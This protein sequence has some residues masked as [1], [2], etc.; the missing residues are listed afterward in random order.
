MTSVRELTT[1]SQFV[2]IQ[3]PMTDLRP[4]LSTPTGR[5]SRPSWPDPI[6]GLEFVRDVGMVRDL[7]PYRLPGRPAGI[8]GWRGERTFCDASKLVRLGLSEIG[9]ERTW[10][11]IHR[12]LFSADV[13]WRLDFG[14]IVNWRSPVHPRTGKAAAQEILDHQV[15][16]QQVQYPMHNVGNA[17]AR[18]LLEVTTAASFATL[19]KPESWWM[20]SG[21]PCVLIDEYQQD[22]DGIAA[23]VDTLHIA[24]KNVPI[25]H[26]R[27]GRHHPQ[28]QSR[29]F[30][31]AIWRA[32]QELETLR[33]V[34]RA[35]RTRPERFSIQH[36]RD[37]L[38]PQ[39]KLLSQRTRGSLDQPSILSLFKELD[40]LDDSDLLP[41][42]H[43]VHGQSKGIARNLES[44][45]RSLEVSKAPTANQQ[46]SFNY[47]I[48]RGGVRMSGDSFNFNDKAFGVFGSNNEVRE[49]NFVNQDAKISD[50]TRE[51]IDALQ[52]LNPPRRRHTRPRKR[53]E[54]ERSVTVLKSEA[55]G[56]IQRAGGDPNRIRDALS[57]IS[58]AAVS[59]G[60]TGVPVIEAVNKLLGAL[61]IQ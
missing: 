4:L 3:F 50:A 61:G 45:M 43:E 47:L 2:N 31:I 5:L 41:L 23:N 60:E 1:S 46:V 6:S 7:N 9:G 14:A 58:S 37:Y 48:A 29:R 38:A 24:G 32:Y 26:L 13:T 19:S 57:K 18:R 39:L 34:V 53:Q 52:Q 16:A 42:L 40:G 55:V 33:Q 21:R 51:L 11:V 22:F 8:V 17:V 28:D 54:L 59:I 15:T 25:L 10:K 27:H 56:E 49:N 36:L 44:F 12:R 20:T 30:R 35:W